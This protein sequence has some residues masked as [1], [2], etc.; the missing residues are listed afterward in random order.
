MIPHC[1][2]LGETCFLAS[3]AL[4]FPVAAQQTLD[5]ETAVGLKQVSDISLSPADDVVAYTLSTPRTAGD[6]PG[7]PFSQ[8]WTV[9]IETGESRLL[10]SES[11]NVSNPRWSPLG[12][13]IAY[14]SKPEGDSASS[15]TQIHLLDPESREIRVLTDH[16]SS[17]SSFEWSPD[18]R[19]I[20]FLAVDALDDEQQA[21]EDAGRDWI[22]VGE[23]ERM[24]RPW[25]VDVETGDTQRLIDTA[26]H[27]SR[28]V[29]VPDSSYLIMQASTSPRADDEMMY[30][31]LMRLNTD[32]GEMVELCETQGKLGPMA[33]SPDRRHLAYQGSKNLN[34]PL[35]QDIMVVPIGGSQ[36]IHL[37]DDL[38]LSVEHV[39]WMDAQNVLA[40]TTKSTQT[41]FSQFSLRTGQRQ[42]FP[43]TRAV[44]SQFEQ[45]AMTPGKYVAIASGVDHPD[46]VFV[47][48]LSGSMQRLTNHNPILDTLT[49]ARTE[50]V[51]WRAKDGWLIQGVLTY[52]VGHQDDVAYPLV[53][54]PHGGPEGVSLHKFNVLPQLLAAHG[55]VVLEPNYRGSGG[56]GVSFSKGDHNDLGGKEFDDIIYGMAALENR[57]LIDRARIGIGGWSYGGY[58]SAM[59]ATHQ[60]SYFR[61]AVMGAGISNWISFAGTT[62]I[63]HEMQLV[64]WNQWWNDDVE[65]QWSRSPLSAINKARTPT[66]IL[67]G[68]DDE[69]V[70][71]GQALEMHQAL[72]DK[73]VPTQLVLYPRSGH[74]V[75]ERAHRIDL[76]ERQIAWFEKYLKN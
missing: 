10:T 66:L 22:V 61:A 23:T 8:L 24:K 48:D 35:P 49:L 44:V 67:H 3:I 75:S 41:I 13:T 39:A 21:A 58:L 72:K 29:W 20:A 26:H 30:S 34:D 5:V 9:T 32:D 54:N 51:N 76:Y 42:D 31:K 28:L 16:P 18:G 6:E 52:P 37:T 53:V 4:T 62:D 70:H 64:H 59:G 2:T 36:P 7:K 63:P 27:V 55:F 74:G 57:G 19:S 73:G 12:S 17:I 71:P 25:R 46:E 11:G 1:R 68:M 47:G 15:Y 33:V 43:T 14:L 50:T 65:M 56:R 60:S 40:L 69:R 38:Q 45:F